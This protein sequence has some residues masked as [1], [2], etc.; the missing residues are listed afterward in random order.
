MKK[1]SSKEDW[2]HADTLIRKRKVEGKDTEIFING[3]PVSAKKL[4]KE[5]GRYAWQQPHGQQS[6]GKTPVT[7]KF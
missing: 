3:K 5:L 2:K 4:K 1:Y 6:L 7:L